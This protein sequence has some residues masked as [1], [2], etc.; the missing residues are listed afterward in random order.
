MKIL[1]KF[2]AYSASRI[3]KW[4]WTLDNRSEH[5][6]NLLTDVKVYTKKGEKCELF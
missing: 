3:I 2:D 1:I 4:P 5:L 6:F